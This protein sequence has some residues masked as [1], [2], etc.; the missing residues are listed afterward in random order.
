MKSRILIIEDDMNILRLEKDY[1]EASGFET[2]TYTDGV[3]GLDCALQN[4]FVLILLDIMLPGINGF[5]IC[6]KIRSEKNVPIIFVSAKREEPDKITGFGFG[7]DDYIVKPF[8]PGELVAR[9]KAHISRY[10]SLTNSDSE[11]CLAVDELK[12]NKMTG[13]AT[14]G[15]ETLSLTKKEFGVLYI[16]ASSP[17]DVF[18]KDELFKSVWQ[19]DS[20]GDT[21]TLTVHI[22]RLREKLRDADPD[23]DYIKTVWGRGYKLK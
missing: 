23:C 17:T 18:T 12:M 9:V 16:L 4:D 11:N 5:E 10:K 13:E 21:S 22:N 1:L 14:M 6:K 19:Y 7:A 2:E 3:K 8:S 20:L 15:G